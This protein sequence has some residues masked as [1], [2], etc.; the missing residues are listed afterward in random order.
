MSNELITQESYA[1]IDWKNT[2]TLTEIKKI[3][4][5]TPL[6]DVEFS[7]FVALG[8][9]TGLNPFLREMWAV[10]YGNSAAQIFVGRDGYR[11]AAQKNPQ[12]D[13]HQSEAVYSNDDFKVCNGE[14]NHSYGMQDRGELIGAYCIVKRHGSSRP[15]YTYVALKEYD[16]KQSVWKT[17]PA[18]MIKKV[19]E[20]QGLRAAFQEQLGGTYAE[21]EEYT[22]E[23]KKVVGNYPPEMSTIDRI[24]QSYATRKGTSN[25]SMLDNK[26]DMCNIFEGETIENTIETNENVIPSYVVETGIKENKS[27]N[28]DRK[29]EK[30]TKEQIVK[31]EGLSY[32]CDF[33]PE[34]LRK[35]LNHYGVAILP[36]L[37]SDQAEDFISILEKEDTKN[38]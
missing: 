5:Q 27:V 12:Y 22:R 2:Q 23:P 3:C 25:E 37:S 7:C 35:A 19:A 6:S 13:Y 21:E 15:I 26:Q 31:I 24:K 1:I 8:K 29:S 20:A 9:S 36:E 28:K 11:K 34:R 14:I 32:M 30:C 17:K 10:K 18:T 16:T 4:S 38:V 33:P